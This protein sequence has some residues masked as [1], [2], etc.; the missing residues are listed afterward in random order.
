MIWLL[1]ILIIQILHCI[2][3]STSEPRLLGPFWLGELFR[4]WF[5]RPW[6]QVA[7]TFSLSGDLNTCA[8]V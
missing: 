8:I 5:G 7:V 1:I 2:S 3:P 4:L 6:F